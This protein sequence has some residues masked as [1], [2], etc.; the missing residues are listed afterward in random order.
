MTQRPCLTCGEPSPGT[1][2]AEHAAE[3]LQRS[4]AVRGTAHQ[5]G[6]TARWQRLSR[7][8]RKAQPFCLWCG[9]PEDLQADHLTWPAR[10][11]RDVRVLCADCHAQAPDRRGNKPRGGTPASSQVRPSREPG[12]RLL[13]GNIAAGEV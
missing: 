11:L 13:S 9:S 7:R 5:R 6:Y 10:T 2:C 8:A 3:H 12:S 1:R 4:D